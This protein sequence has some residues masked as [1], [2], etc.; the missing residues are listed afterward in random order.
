MSLDAARRVRAPSRSESSPNTLMADAIGGRRAVDAERIGLTE[1]LLK[2][3]N[4]CHQVGID[5]R[6]RVVYRVHR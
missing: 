1:H 4:G 2:G 3:R 6:D 5:G